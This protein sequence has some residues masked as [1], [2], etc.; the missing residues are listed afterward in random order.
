MS[1]APAGTAADAHDAPRPA[2][3]ARVDGLS[4]ARERRARRRRLRSLPALVV[5]ALRLCWSARRR[6]L[7]LVFGVQ[8]LGA[9]LLGVQV[10]VGREALTRVFSGGAGGAGA[11]TGGDLLPL[12]GGPLLALGGL[13]VVA[14]L[15]GAVRGQ[16]MRLLSEAVQRAVWRRVVDTT[17]TVP[18]DRF[19]DPEF[20]DRLQRVSTN[21]VS[22]PVGVAQGLVSILGGAVGAVGLV[23]ALWA[24]DPLLLPLLLLA[25]VP[26]FLVSRRGG[27]LEFDFAV[28]Q[29]GPYRVRSYLRSALTGRREAKEVRAY[30]LAAP[31]GARYERLLQEYE[32]ALTR[33]VGRRM[34]LSLLSQVLTAASVVGTVAVLLWLVDS[35]RLSLADAGAAGAAAPLLASRLQS[36]AGGVGTVL[37]AGLFLDDLRGFLR[38]GTPAGRGAQGPAALEPLVELEVDGVGYRYPQ[39]A[40]PALSGVSLRVRRGEVV[41]L[42]GEN[43][44]GK[45][46][47][48]K[49]LAGLLPPGEGTIRWNGT[50]VAALDPAAVREH[51]AVV[52]QDFVQW[53]FSAHDNIAVGRPDR[54]DEAGAVPAAAVQAGA[55]A[56]L[57]RL[58]GGYRTLLSAELAGG[59]DLSLGQWQR[60]ALARAFYRGAGLVILDEPTAALDAR[61]EAELFAGIRELMSGRTVVLVSH[62]FSSVRE[63]DRIVVLREGRVD[64]TGTHEELLARGGL[65]A[66]LYTL[67]AQAYLDEGTA[68]AG[69]APTGRHAAHR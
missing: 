15:A 16:R 50:D 9:L 17:T 31:L 5:E 58:P 10:L 3:P 43:G 1:T 24:I 44:S 39:S 21:A 45:T 69:R 34:R 60:V 64:D 48:S 41:A 28:A 8:L 68:R 27:R 49:L 67:Q 38:L 26:V 20:Y 46:T 66:E 6:D 61:A 37:E 25:G 40:G 57:R 36:L 30:G 59:V 22:R 54:P 12:V 53:Q 19:D 2:P 35:G 14:G 32:D 52:F 7:V 55:D 11:G 62:R 4:I 42:V 23:V 13:S 29:S 51:V 63:A 56:L 33:H 65:Y 18:L 47:L